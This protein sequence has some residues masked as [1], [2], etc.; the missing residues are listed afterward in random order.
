MDLK[1]RI[2]DKGIKIVWLAEKIGV[3]QPFLSMC[4]NGDRTLARDKM[5]KLKELL[6]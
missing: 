2:K 6:N 1:Q 3:S 5:E 4:L